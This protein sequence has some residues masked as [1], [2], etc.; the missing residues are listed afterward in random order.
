MKDGFGREI[1]YM[2]ISITERCNLRCWYCRGE[3]VQ[4][5]CA[6]QE[7]QSNMPPVSVQ[8]TELSPQSFAEIVEAAVQ[9]GIHKIRITGGEPLVRPEAVE[10]CQRIHGIPGVEELAL[11]TN[12]VLLEGCAAQLKHAG[13]SRVNISLDTLRADRYH[14]VTAGGDIQAVFRGIKEAVAVGLLPIKINVVLMKEINEDEIVSFVNLT[15]TAPIEVRFIERMPMAGA[16][17]GA[18]HD[19]PGEAVLLRVPDL[20]P[21][22]D[23]GVA[24]LYRL[25]GSMGR[26]GLICPVSSHFCSSC[27]RIR[28]TS[29]GHIKPCLH[30]EEEIDIAHLHGVELREALRQAIQ[31]KPMEHEDFRRGKVSRAGRSMNQIGG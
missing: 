7:H 25:P 4:P 12:G 26:V 5:E 21:E 22:K 10:I 24:R 27:N 18:E 3:Q 19:L 2:R 11:T 29:D 17:Q 20:I 31:G 30:F 9:L 13:V 28:L 14:A 6:V 16:G 8:D 15:K 1:S 23:S